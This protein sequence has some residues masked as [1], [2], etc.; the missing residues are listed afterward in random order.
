MTEW[1]ETG[2]SQTISHRELLSAEGS[3]HA[4][5]ENGT[6]RGTRSVGQGEWQ[7]ESRERERERNAGN[8]IATSQSSDDKT[9]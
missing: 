4:A 9:L 8:V 7:E 2:F 5:R 1:N 3:R 6:A